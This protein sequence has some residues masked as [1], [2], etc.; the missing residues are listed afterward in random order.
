MLNRRACAIA[1]MLSVSA[2]LS[3]CGGSTNSSTGATKQPADDREAITKWRDANRSELRAGLGELDDAIAAIT[4][5][6]KSARVPALTVHCEALEAG[7]TKLLAIAPPA[8]IA[9]H[10]NRSMTMFVQ[11]A[12]H[13]VTA[14]RDKDSEKLIKAIQEELF[15]SMDE[16]KLATDDISRATGGSISG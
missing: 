16:L 3:A 12:Q 10:F 14:L 2:M 4:A 5:D 15:A 9:V 7:A 11:A 13:C 6:A 1:I 8:S